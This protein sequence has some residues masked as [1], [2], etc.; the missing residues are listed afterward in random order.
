MIIERKRMRKVSV[1]EAISKFATG[2]Y[3]GKQGI[4]NIV[5]I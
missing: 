1:S 2:A 5:I 4:V 3:N